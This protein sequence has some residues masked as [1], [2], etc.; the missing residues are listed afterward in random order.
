MDW[1]RFANP[2]SGTLGEGVQTSNPKKGPAAFI[3]HGFGNRIRGESFEDVR[4][5]ADAAWTSGTIKIYN[6]R[7]QL[8]AERYDGVWSSLPGMVR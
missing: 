6:G 7:G 5:A 1:Q 8:V 2:F 3:A 4:N